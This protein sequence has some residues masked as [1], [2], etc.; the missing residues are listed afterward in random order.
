M[1]T[2]KISLL[3]RIGYLLEYA[4]VAPLAFL[5]SLVPWPLIPVLSR[6]F[7]WFL[8]HFDRR[9]REVAYRNFPVIYSDNPPSRPEQDALLREVFRGVARVGLELLKIR[10]LRADNYAKFCRMEG[11]ENVDKA[12]AKGKGLIVITAHLGNWEFLGSLPAKMGRNVVAI[13]NRQF[14]PY[15]DRW[16]KDIRENKGKLRNLYNEIGDLTKIIKHLRSGGI[17]AI[18]ADQTYYFK[19]IFVPFFGRTA[20]TA[21]GPARLHLKFGAPIIMAF[22]IR[23]PDGKYVLTYEEPKEFEPTGNMEEDCKTV[24]TWVNA[25]FER[26]IL[27]HPDQWFSLLHGRWDRSKPEDFN[28]Q[29][30][31]P[32]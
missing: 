2:R 4:V 15:T 22:G 32:Y 25:Q 3:R 12:L 29:E 19:P 26:M 16:I 11:Y 18:V 13:I 30:D 31:Q 6:F 5:L 17:V 7:G 21:D 9:D 24:M 27:R 20:A 14:N 10:D 8:F 1:A 23:Q 28:D